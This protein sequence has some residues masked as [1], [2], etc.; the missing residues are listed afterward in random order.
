MSTS[1]SLW[2]MTS[3]IAFLPAAKPSATSA[4]LT[5][6][7]NI[8]IPQLLTI[9]ATLMQVHQ[10]NSILLE[11]VCAQQHMIKSVIMIILHIIDN[12]FCPMPKFWILH[13]TLFDPLGSPHGK[14]HLFVVSIRKIFDRGSRTGFLV[15]FFLRPHS[16][17]GTTS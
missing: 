8:Y 16:L 12:L 4:A 9:L 6:Q 15:F 14:Y 7:Q 13:V 11:L 2:Y 1:P 17:L 5:A 3:K 10:M